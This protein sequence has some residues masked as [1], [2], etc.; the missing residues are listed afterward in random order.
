[1]NI[2]KT[3]RITPAIASLL[4]RSNLRQHETDL[5]A[6]APFADVEIAS[7]KKP[8]NDKLQNATVVASRLRRSNLRHFGTDLLVLAL[9]T[10][11]RLLRLR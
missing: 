8:R 11:Q 9:S 4:R 7:A 5:S 3:T 2:K 10:T 1:M 6:V